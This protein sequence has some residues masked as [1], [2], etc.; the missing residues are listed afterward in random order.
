M[1]FLSAVDGSEVGHFLI[2]T[3]DSYDNKKNMQIGIYNDKDVYAFFISSEY[4]DYLA[5]WHYDYNS[6]KSVKTIG[7]INGVIL[8]D[9][10][11]RNYAGVLVYTKIIDA[12]TIFTTFLKF[13][14]YNK[15]IQWS[16]TIST[17]MTHI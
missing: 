2:Y 16:K 12:I 15:L 6:V 9:L 5:Y 11:I 1:L 17:G 3:D 8:K 13:T 7:N 4:P 10:S 14:P